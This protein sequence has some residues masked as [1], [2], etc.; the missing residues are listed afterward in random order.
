[1]ELKYIVYITVNTVNGKFYFGVH[2]TNPEVFDGY[3]GDGVYRQS[4]A[5]DNRAFHKAVRKYGYDKFKRTTIKIFPHTEEGLKA[6]FDFEAEIVNSTLLKSKTCYN[7]AL[8][9][10]GAP[11][12]DIRKTV[13]MFDLNGNYL[14]SFKSVKD[15]AVYLQTDN[16]N[17]SCKSIR[18]NC[19][20]KTQSSLGYFWSYKKE[21]TYKK[22]ELWKKIAQY[23]LSG[24]FIRTF[25][26]IAEAEETLQISTINQAIRKNYACGGYQWKY[27]EGEIP[28]EIPKYI[29]TCNKNLII[30][31]LMFDLNNNLIKEYNSVKECIKD[32][33]DKNFST[34]QINRVIKNIIKSHKGYVFKYKDDDIVSLD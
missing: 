8:G 15:A 23:T 24:K 7:T 14:R 29:S 11:R 20:G 13:Y 27:F 9:G 28:L 31:I 3:I 16:I 17:S 2:E 19:L 10:Q 22:P 5:N 21:F 6:A 12:P 32:N 4:N 34:G 33:T 25:N 18:N 30:P 26:N 1:M